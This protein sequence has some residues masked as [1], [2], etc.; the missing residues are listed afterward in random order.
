MSKINRRAGATSQ[1]LQVYI[2]DTTGAGLTGLVFNST[3]LTA[4][5]HRD[6][7][8][9]ATSIALVTMTVGT[10]TSKG[11]KEIDS[12][13][14]PGWY[15]FCPP[16]AALATGA[17]SVGLHL[18][19]A[20]NMADL[21]IEID[22]DPQVDLYL[23]QGVTPN[24]LISSG[25]LDA[26]FNLRTNVA[27]SGTS[28]TIQLD[29]GNPTGTSGIFD[30]DIIALVG[31]TGVGQSRTIQNYSASGICTVFPAWATAPDTTSIFTIIPG[32]QPTSGGVFLA[33]GSITSGLISSGIVFIASGPFVG[34]LSGQLVGI[35][36]GQLSGY[37]V[38]PQSGQTFIAS[39]SITSG[40]I[41]SG[42]FV[43]ATSTLASGAL[44]G[45]LVGI[46][47]GQLSGQVVNLLSGN[48]VGVWSGTNV[49]I[50]SGQIVTVLSGQ[51]SGQ[52]L[53][54][55]SGQLSGFSVTLLSGQLSGYQ[56]DTT[57]NFDKSGYWLNASGLDAIQP[58]SGVNFRQMQAAT[59]A[60]AAGMTS[61]AGTSQF[62][63]GNESGI[64][65]G[66]YST[67]LSGNRTLINLTL[68]T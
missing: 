42:I 2:Q 21:P 52:L 3:G 43:T 47:S 9:T 8:T 31:G 5:Y 63:T 32:G 17:A 41:S 15:Q 26:A 50:F 65:R 28:T 60:A 37:A 33:S 4:Y 57:R 25:R 19:G 36:S 49:N 18:K 45:Q 55:L 20:A 29:A 51:L 66:T 1:I 23:W 34:S 68:P 11:F 54:L 22:L 48:Q 24:A 40:V 7:D 13:N 58:E 62:F 39:G 16:D 12:T 10:F 56:T 27:R 38:T 53:G 30:E 6:T 14:M 64:L 59:F 35:L 44:S 67:D 46:L 61:G